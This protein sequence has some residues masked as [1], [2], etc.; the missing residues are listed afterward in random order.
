M[1]MNC[2]TPNKSKKLHTCQNYAVV[3]TDLPAAS[4]GSSCPGHNNDIEYLDILHY[5]PKNIDE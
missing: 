2:N 4:A 5:E 1:F 3:V